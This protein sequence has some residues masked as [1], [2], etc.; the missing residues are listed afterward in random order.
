[1]IVDRFTIPSAHF[2]TW[3]R[4]TSYRSSRYSRWRRRLDLV[5]RR[6]GT[7]KLTCS[8]RCPLSTPR[9]AFEVNTTDTRMSRA[10]RRGLRLRPSYRCDSQLRTGDGRAYRFLFEPVRS[11]PL[12]QPR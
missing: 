11:C 10:S 12:T 3:F 9:V 6:C 8:E 2:A 4:T 7:E 1:M 5:P